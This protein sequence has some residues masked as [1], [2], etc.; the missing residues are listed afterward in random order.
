MDMKFEQKRIPAPQ[1]LGAM[2][3][4]GFKRFRCA[5][6]ILGGIE[7]MHMVAKGE[8]KS[9]CRWHHSVAERFQDLAK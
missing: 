6:I 1:H 9:E 5:R 2:P 4:L 3:R 7:L 8:M